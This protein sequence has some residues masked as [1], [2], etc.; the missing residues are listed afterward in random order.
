MTRGFIVE[1]DSEILCRECMHKVKIRACGGVGWSFCPVCGLEGPERLIKTFFCEDCKKE[2]P[3]GENRKPPL[4][5]FYICLK[6]GL[7]VHKNNLN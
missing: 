7:I 4:E 5:M 2:T 3:H 1:Y 6:C